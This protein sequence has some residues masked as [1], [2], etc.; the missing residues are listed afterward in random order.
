MKHVLIVEDNPDLRDI[1]SRVF[2]K[3]DF[4]VSTAEDGQAALDS[5]L[6]QIPDVILLDINMP[7]V[8]GFEVLTH[9]QQY[10][11]THN[12][13]VIVVTGNSLAMQDDRADLAD[14]L[15]VK[16]VDINDLILFTIRLSQ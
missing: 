3:Y 10:K 1:F 2:T 12:L 4:Q 11:E 7:K 8:S 6:T 15:L 14:L 5:F 13:K 9:V 16:P